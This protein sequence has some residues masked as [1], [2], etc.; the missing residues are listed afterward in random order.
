MQVWAAVL[1]FRVVEPKWGPLQTV[2]LNRLER[3]CMSD[4][5]SVNLGLEGLSTLGFRVRKQVRFAR[6]QFGSA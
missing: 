5:G 1:G 3:D 4:W 2:L 6:T